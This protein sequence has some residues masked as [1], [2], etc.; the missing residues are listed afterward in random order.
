[1]R[2]ACR[3]GKT[4]CCWLAVSVLLL[5]ERSLTFYLCSPSDNKFLKESH[6]IFSEY[7]YTKYSVFWLTNLQKLN[8]SIWCE[9]KLQRFCCPPSISTGRRVAKVS[10]L[11]R[12]NFCTHGYS[13]WNGLALKWVVVPFPMIFLTRL[14]VELIITADFFGQLS[15][16]KKSR[17][18]CKP[19]FKF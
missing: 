12:L 13:P 2:S 19:V 7:L 14:T 9:T 15:H 5:S 16:Q 10:Q 1:M 11:V 17:W 4:H 8:L 18:A 3:K 6:R